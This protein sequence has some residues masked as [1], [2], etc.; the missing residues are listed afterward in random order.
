M[1]LCSIP[2]AWPFTRSLLAFILMTIGVALLLIWAIY[3]IQYNNKKPIILRSGTLLRYFMKVNRQ[4]WAMALIFCFIVIGFELIKKQLTSYDP[5]F[6]LPD[7]FDPSIIFPLF[8][9]LYLFV[10]VMHSQGLGCHVAENI[11]VSWDRGNI[12]SLHLAGRP[13][14]VLKAL[15]GNITKR[16]DDYAKLFEASALPST[17]RLES[18]LF[19][20]HVS[21]RSASEL[22]TL[23][24]LLIFPKLTALIETIK[25]KP[26]RFWRV[27][28]VR[29]FRLALLMRLVMR[30]G[31]I[32]NT[33]LIM[34]MPDFAEVTCTVCGAPTTPTIAKSIERLQLLDPKRR[35]GVLPI[36]KFTTWEVIHLVT[37][38]PNLGSQ[39]IP[40]T[41]GFQFTK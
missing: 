30:F 12:L 10:G 19:L 11:K 17:V 32:N 3:A 40:W 23:H 29:V 31:R 13:N 28:T 8:L 27:L 14:E 34:T 25:A 21:D 24:A 7:A 2:S 36:R 20:R 4:R 26:R 6:V 33:L 38:Y 1:D 37:N 16:I 22:H 9:A 18:W 39:L 41:T 35:F 5:C 15:R